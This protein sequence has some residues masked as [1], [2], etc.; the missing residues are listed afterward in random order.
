MGSVDWL[1]L[2]EQMRRALV[3]AREGLVEGFRD[4]LHGQLHKIA[5]EAQFGDFML[6]DMGRKDW[7]RRFRDLYSLHLTDSK[8]AP[9]CLLGQV[10]LQ[11]FLLFFTDG[12]S[13]AMWFQDGKHGAPTGNAKGSFPAQ[14]QVQHGL[15]SRSSL[16]VEGPS[17]HEHV[18]RLRHHNETTKV[19]NAINAPSDQ[20]RAPRHGQSQP[21]VEAV[22]RQA[23]HP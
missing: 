8:K 20:W 17:L 14:L 11:L 19:R 4:G 7:V 18:A 21:F 23:C 3:Y 6:L 9:S 5:F 13:H 22:C 2:R 16:L 1:S 12:R 15:F 10:S